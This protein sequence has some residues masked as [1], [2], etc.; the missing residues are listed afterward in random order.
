VR[1]SLSVSLLL[2]AAAVTLPFPSKTQRPTPQQQQQPQP[3]AQQASPQSQGAPV[4]GTPLQSLPP[5]AAPQHV[6]S[7]VVLDPGHGGTDSGARGAT[8]AIEK[9]V[10]LLMSRAV[11]S[12]LERQDLRVV[13]TREGDQNPSFDDRAAIANA[14]HNSVFVSLHVSSTG[15]AGTARVYFFDVSGFPETA[16]VAGRLLT[17]DTAQKPFVELSRR[18]ADLMQVQLA[19][20]FPKS[21]EIS[22]GVPVRTLR[23]VAAPAVGV[24]ISSVTALDPNAL[25]AMA[26]ALATAIGRAVNAF[27]PM[28]EAGGR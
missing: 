1:R 21:P 22:L 2:I 8:G 17:W 6:L 20:K 7:T 11:R 23:S 27:K 18:L 16:S 4:P 24:E 25:E 9:D 10:V 26:P 3:P 12:E 28:Y 5:T 19:Q 14:Q 15:T 13:M